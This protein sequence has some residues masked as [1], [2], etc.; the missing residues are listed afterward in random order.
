M[1]PIEYSPVRPNL[2]RA[3][4]T[5]QQRPSECLCRQPPELGEFDGVQQILRM[6][7]LQSGFHFVEQT[8]RSFADLNNNQVRQLRGIL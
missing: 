1:M 8:A 7:E 6:E 2:Q 3:R 4:L 5:G